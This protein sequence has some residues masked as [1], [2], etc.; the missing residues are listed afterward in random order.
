LR[1]RASAAM[2]GEEQGHD[3][4]RLRHRGRDEHRSWGKIRGV[5]QGQ[6]PWSEAEGD[7]EQAGKDL[8]WGL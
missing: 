7:L 5:E 2:D 4:A 3:S 1:W 8:G 6:A